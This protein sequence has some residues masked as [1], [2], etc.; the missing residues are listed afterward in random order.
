MQNIGTRA[1]QSFFRIDLVSNNGFVIYSTYDKKSIM[2]RNIRKFTNL[3]NDLKNSVD[4]KI[5]YNTV[6]RRFG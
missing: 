3:A 1:G 2:Q 5:A 4:N 6:E